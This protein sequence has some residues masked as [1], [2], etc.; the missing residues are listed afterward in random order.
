L[1]DLLEGLAHLRDYYPDLTIKIADMG[2]VVDA[3][4]LPEDTIVKK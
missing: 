4:M 1:Q 2:S 3:S